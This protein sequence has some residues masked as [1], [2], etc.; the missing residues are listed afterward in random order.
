LSRFTRFFLE[1]ELHASPINFSQHPDKFRNEITNIKVRDVLS[2]YASLMQWALRRENVKHAFSPYQESDNLPRRMGG[3]S[4][5]TY[6]LMMIFHL[7]QKGYLPC[8]QT[9]YVGDTKLI[10]CEHNDCNVWFQTDEDVVVSHHS[11]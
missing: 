9:A 6:C 5:Y 10:I 11:S 2:V 3:I 8:L 7:Q 1:N 4:S